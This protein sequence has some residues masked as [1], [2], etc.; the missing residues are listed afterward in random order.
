M[1][2]AEL[3]VEKDD[4]K[5][6]G[7]EAL[8]PLELGMEVGGKERQL[9]QPQLYLEIRGGDNNN[10]MWWLRMGTDRNV[11]GREYL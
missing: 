1:D 7:K 2:L 11:G 8:H 4:D 3:R 5:G 9:A 6:C 10:G